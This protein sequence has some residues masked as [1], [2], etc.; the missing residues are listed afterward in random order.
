MYCYAA[1]L[2]PAK[3]G[4]ETMKTFDASASNGSELCCIVCGREIPGGN[5]F[6]RIR[7]GS[8]RVACCSPRCAEKYAE[9]AA[10]IGSRFDAGENGDFQDLR[11]AYA[12][13]VG[14]VERNS[15][16]YE[17]KFRWPEWEQEM[18]QE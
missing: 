6:A 14:P 8:R 7:A 16:S 17:T 12:G 10:S 4:A 5:W 15:V 1:R 2:E 11:A 18:T 13:Q 3:G 9:G